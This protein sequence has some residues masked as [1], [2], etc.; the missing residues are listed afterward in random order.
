M[1][2]SK[3]RPSLDEDHE[4]ITNKATKARRPKRVLESSQEEDSQD[5]ESDYESE[6]SD[7]DQRS[8]SKQT[9]ERKRE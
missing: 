3:K 4:D 7:S 6:S 1:S 5:S 9:T 2:Q 8:K